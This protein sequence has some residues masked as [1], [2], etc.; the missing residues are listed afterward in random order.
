M[1]IKNRSNALTRDVESIQTECLDTWNEKRT[2]Q[3]S[4]AAPFLETTCWQEVRNL[5]AKD[6]G[7]CCALAVRITDLMREIYPAFSNDGLFAR[8]SAKPILRNFLRIHPQNISTGL[9][10]GDSAGHCHKAIFLRRYNGNIFV[11]PQEA[12][13]VA[14]HRIGPSALPWIQCPDRA[15]QLSILDCL[16]P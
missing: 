7:T 14:K 15:H 9:R 4:A 1:P 16:I 5:F 11:G 6:F 12:F 13:A 8:R 2:C 3:L 10:S